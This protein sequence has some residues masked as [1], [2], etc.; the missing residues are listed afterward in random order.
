MSD[1]GP[2][3]Y[4]I[5]DYAVPV[6]PA[7]RTPRFWRNLTR[8]LAL[9]SWLYAGILLLLRIAANWPGADCWPLHLFF[10][11][12][13]WLLSIPLLLL[14]GLSVWQRQWWPAARLQSFWR[15]IS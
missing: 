4:R 2:K 5:A 1:L 9:C 11:G 3:R 12:P 14:L 7:P 15:A 6:A 10:F 13:R 8:R